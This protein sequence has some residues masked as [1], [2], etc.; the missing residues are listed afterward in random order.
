MDKNEYRLKCK[1]FRD[2]AR[3]SFKYLI[4]DFNYELKHESDRSKSGSIIFDTLI[5]TNEKR[6]RI[7]KISNSFNPKDYGF[8]I[9]MMDIS[10]KKNKTFVLEKLV[11]SYPLKNQDFEQ[12]YLLKISERFKT[13]HYTAILGKSFYEDAHIRSTGANREKSKIK[14]KHI[15][16]WLFLYL[17][18]LI[19]Q[20]LLK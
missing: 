20:F 10:K 9:K 11:F 3:A 16:L 4:D 6:N 14:P 13:E 5:Y 12:N 15:L 8:E 7:I 19:M 2:K 17:I 18:V 1:N